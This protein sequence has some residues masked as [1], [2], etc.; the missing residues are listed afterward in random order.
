MI[1]T[2]LSSLKIREKLRLMLY[3]G[4]GDFGY[5]FEMPV[6]E[7]L[8]G[9]LDLEDEGPEGEDSEA[10]NLSLVNVLLDKDHSVCWHGDRI[11]EGLLTFD[12]GASRY[13]QGT[14][15]RVGHWTHLVVEI[16]LL[17]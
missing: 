5:P 3:H 16:F 14:E 15:K 12:V 6:E 13:P 10:I 2:R 1:F 8:D 7:V 9:H 4:G 17:S 11:F